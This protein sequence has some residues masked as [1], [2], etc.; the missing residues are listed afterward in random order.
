M[1]LLGWFGVFFFLFLFLAFGEMLIIRANSPYTTNL[2]QMMR[3]KAEISPT[4]SY[5]LLKRENKSVQRFCDAY[6][7]NKKSRGREK[8]SWL[9]WQQVN[10]EQGKNTWL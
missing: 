3:Q 6:A 8:K 4:S 9:A 1:Q 10:N 7:C 2:H 5:T